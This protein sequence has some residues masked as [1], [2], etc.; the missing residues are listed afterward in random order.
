MQNEHNPI[1]TIL[2]GSWRA[3]PD[4]LSVSQASLSA[5]VPVIESTGAGSLAWNRIARN[6]SLRASSHAGQ[7]RN[8]AQTLALGAARH[9]LALGDLARL[10]HRNDINPL[11]FKGWAVAHHYSERHLRPMGMLIFALRPG[12]LMSLPIF[13]T[14][15]GFT[16]PL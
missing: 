7:L 6:A 4:P 9:D 13:S 3:E 10:F 1:G 11:L 12:A 15:T 2:A 14:A 16:D 8:C 5:S